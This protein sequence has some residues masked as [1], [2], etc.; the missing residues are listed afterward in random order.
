MP[1]ID[2]DEP[3]VAGSA[4][5][6]KYGTLTFEDKWVLVRPL[7]WRYMVPLC[8]LLVI[9]LQIDIELFPSFC[10]FGEWSSF[11]IFNAH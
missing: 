4:V 3:V 5:A 11:P 8:R 1:M 10:L 6:P 9:L 7:L 2:E